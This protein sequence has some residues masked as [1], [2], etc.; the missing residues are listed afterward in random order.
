MLMHPYQGLPDHNFWR[1]AVSEVESFRLD[2]VTHPKFQ[3]APSDRVSTAGSC[4]AQHISRHLRKTGFAYFVPESG[5][6]LPPHE[7]QALQYGTFSARYG[8]I[9][10]VRQLRQLFDEAFGRRSPAVPAWL[11]EDQRLADPLRP[12]IQPDGFS[13]LEA[14]QNSRQTHLSHVCSVFLESDVLIFTLGLTETWRHRPSGEV[15]PLAP[16]VS[17]GDYDPALY[18]FVNFSL[19]ETQL[20]LLSF[21]SDLQQLNPRIRVLLTVSPV[22][23]IA[24]YEPRHVL[25]SNTLSK[26]VLRV[27]AQAATDAF[28]WVDYFPSYELF[29]GAHHQGRYFQGDL[30]E[31]APTGVAHAMRLFASH[32][33]K[34]NASFSAPAGA[35][36]GPPASGAALPEIVCDEESVAQTS[37]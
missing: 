27:A 24:T 9:Y 35:P 31:A 16:G 22:P 5:S 25:V 21:L 13:S 14:L 7:Q 23:L 33:L 4:F 18:E 6:H 17:A 32:Y 15:Y 8:N 20:D 3:I 29:A 36:S 10:T 28:P 37:F 2:P 1:K 34:A 19:K 11:R 12:N 26:S 30:R